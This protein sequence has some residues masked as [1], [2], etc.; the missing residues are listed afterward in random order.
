[1]TCYEFIMAAAFVNAR[2]PLPQASPV[3]MAICDGTLEH[4]LSSFSAEAQ[5][6]CLDELLVCHGVRPWLVVADGN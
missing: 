1:M 6:E 2:F 4:S 3:L 5:S